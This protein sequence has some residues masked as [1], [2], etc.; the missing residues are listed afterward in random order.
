MPGVLTSSGKLLLTTSGKFELLGGAAVPPPPPVSGPPP[1]TV[2]GLSS[3]WDASVKPATATGLTTLAD[4][5]GSTLLTASAASAWIPRLA[6]G[7]GGV[8][9]EVTQLA[10][11]GIGA[12][13]ATLH[14]LLDPDLSLSASLPFGAGGALTLDLVWTR[15]NLRQ[16]LV[17]HVAYPLMSGSFVGGT[18]PLLVIGGVTVLGMTNTG[19]GDALVMWPN[20]TSTTLASNLTPRHT[21]A[22]RLRGSH[23]AGWDVYLNGT[24]LTGSP[25]ASQLGSA[26]TTALVRF[27]GAGGGASAQCWFHEAYAFS[28]ALS[29]SECATLDTYLA[30]WP[31]GTRKAAIL[32]AVGQSN[33]GYLADGT[34]RYR[35]MS[36]GISYLT[37]L[38]SFTILLSNGPGSDDTIRGGHGLLGDNTNYLAGAITD[39]PTT[40]P[41]GTTGPGVN[42]RR[43]IQSLPAYLQADVCGLF[44]Y[45]SENDAGFGWSLRNQFAGMVKQYNTF[46]KS[47]PQAGP[48]RD[49]SNWMLA[50][51]SDIPFGG[52]EGHAS[53][54]AAIK[55]VVDD[56]TQGAILWLLNGVGAIQDGGTFNPATGVNSGGDSLHLDR[57]DDARAGLYGI[58]PL[59]RRL[60]A[61]GRV[62][63]TL[64]AG[65]MV[66][67]GPQVAS[68][69]WEGGTVSGNAATPTILVTVQHDVGSDLRVPLLAVNGLGW[70]ILDGP[71]P[72]QNTPR[73][74]GTSCVRVSATTLRV[75]FASA[76]TQP[77]ASTLLFYIYSEDNLPR[78]NNPGAPGRGNLITD[79]YSDTVAVPAVIGFDVGA[80]LGALY[81]VDRPL[82]AFPFGMALS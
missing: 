11:Y 51:N 41:L 2:S 7:L 54:K 45:Y 23:A 74:L 37:G 36:R 17:D 81:R 47:F 53:H 80:D 77:L 29:D 68:V 32:M 34:N 35:D 63:N 73:I 5:S 55:L 10:G 71:T 58:E 82:A 30:R 60:A 33:S 3:W 18:S 43:M 22:L 76:P 42:T 48:T 72:V 49:A 1:S 79:N 40:V 61:I 59:A 67:G 28:R 25:V 66:R 75:R 46:A 44:A 52:G 50:W 6:G 21:Y 9:L 14:P 13:A 31:L 65:I 78:A 12:W 70:V 4:K 8:G 16:A 64:P 19:A 24:K 57:T 62:E 20:G 39:D 38:A 15:P 56:P 26:P 69:V 27:L